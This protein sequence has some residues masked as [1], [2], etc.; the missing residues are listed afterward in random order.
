MRHNVCALAAIAALAWANTA[1]ATTVRFDVV[2][3][4]DNAATSVTYAPGAAVPY[5]I[6]AQ[7]ISDD[8]TTADNNGLA[9]F[10]LELTTN[11]TVTQRALTAFP[12]QIAQAFTLVQSLGTLTN[13]DIAQIGG[14][15]N[16]PGGGTVTAGIGSTRQLIG[17][18]NFVAPTTLG[19][20][21]VGIGPSTS[22]QVLAA[23]SLT[24]VK[25]ATIQAGPGFSIVVAETTTPTTS[26]QISS[27]ALVAAGVFGGLAV[28]VFVAALFLSGPLA[29]MLA[30]LLLPL[31]GIVMLMNI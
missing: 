26:S 29:A 15:Q 23:G 24:N 31:L 21:T 1:T 17:E 13:D 14:G 2:P 8:T 10:S 18:G 6:Y 20:Y 27:N 16:T 19:T 11:L 30:I 12:T 22:A 25:Q 28:M 7:V 4:A 9:F 5:Q 3:T